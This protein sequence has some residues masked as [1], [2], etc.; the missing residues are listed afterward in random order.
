MTAA[1]QDTLANC[2][3]GENDEAGPIII[4]NRLDE[5][6]KEL[7]RLLTMGE[8]EITDRRIK[9]ISDEML[10]LK[11]MKKR[12]EL[13]AQQ[14]IGRENKAKEILSLIRAEN[15]DLTE[16]L[17]PWYTGSLK[18]LPYFPKKK[19]AS[20]LRA[21]LKSPSPFTKKQAQRNAG[22]AYPA[23]VSLC[24]LFYIDRN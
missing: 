8:N 20:D 11:Q 21:D 6:D 2:I 19:F 14:S 9:Q 12:A 15:L 10:R 16:T 17:T 4:K 22:R 7:D 18:E 24:L 13:S 3:A 5:L 23:G 1:L